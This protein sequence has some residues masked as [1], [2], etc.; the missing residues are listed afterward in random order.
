MVVVGGR[1]CCLSCFFSCSSV[2]L[3]GV[4]LLGL[5]A[6]A[7]V[8]ASSCQRVIHKK[9]GD[10]VELPSC[11]P[12]EGVSIAV[13]SYGETKIA[14]KD[15]NVSGKQFQGRLFLNPTNFSLTLR[16]L[17]ASDSGN[18]S[19]ESA[20]KDGKQRET[21]T[22]SLHVHAKSSVLFVIGLIGGVL[23]V[24]L[25]PLLLLCWIKKMKGN[26]C[27]QRKSQRANQSS[28]AFQTFSHGDQQHPVYSSLLHGDTSVYE[29]TAGRGNTGKGRR[30]GPVESCD[31][32]IMNP[33]SP[34]GTTINTSSSTT[35]T[36]HSEVN[37]CRS[38]V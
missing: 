37:V 7:Y 36:I 9:V 31:Y 35:F 2:L 26:V 6:S 4:C 15:H 3:V 29:T 16:E 19:F 24:V 18:F 5:H 12:S 33:D 20:D 8:D 38:S 10:T 21:F 1:L 17:M 25:L 34:A 14:D 28:A 23:L 11:S 30:G 32:S 13:W 22:V 27:L